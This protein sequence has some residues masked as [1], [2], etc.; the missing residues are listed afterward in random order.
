M[1]YTLE[2]VRSMV[3]AETYTFE[4][5]LVLLRAARAVSMPFLFTSKELDALI[6]DAQ[7]VF[8]EWE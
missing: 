6:L 8:P 5:K 1:T 3:R 4:Q 7:R 2:D